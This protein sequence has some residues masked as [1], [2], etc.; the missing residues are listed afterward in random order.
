MAKE[1]GKTQRIELVRTVVAHVVVTCKHSFARPT[2]RATRLAPPSRKLNRPCVMAPYGLITQCLSS[3]PFHKCGRIAVALIVDGL[4]IDGVPHLMGCIEAAATA[5]RLLHPK[6][7]ERMTAAQALEHPWLSSH[8][9][10]GD[11]LGEV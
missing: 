7:D 1:G 11:H 10:T 8:E 5:Y 4:S 3:S 9:S 6:Q 2:T